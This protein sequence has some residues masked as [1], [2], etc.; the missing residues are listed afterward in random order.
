MCCQI[1]VVYEDEAVENQ[2]ECGSKQYVYYSDQGTLAICFKCGRFHSED[3]PVELV[4]IFI[5][6]PTVLMALIKG[7]YFR[8]LG[9]IKDPD[10]WNSLNSMIN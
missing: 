7:D 10:I 2:C 8:V 3:L 9:S 1:M 6:D 5:N 4:D